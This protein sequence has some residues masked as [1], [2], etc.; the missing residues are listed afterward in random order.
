MAN[1]GVET[2]PVD[3]RKAGPTASLADRERAATAGLGVEPSIAPD[4]EPS[5]APGATFSTAPGGPTDWDLVVRAHDQREAGL[6]V[7]SGPRGSD[8][9]AFAVLFER[10]AKAVFTYLLRLTGEAALAEDLVQEAFLAAY[11]HLGSLRPERAAGGQAATLRPWLL[12]VARNL[13]FSHFRRG[14][15]NL[16]PKRQVPPGLTEANSGPPGGGAANGPEELVLREETAAEVRRAVSRLSPRYRDPLLLHYAAGL[17]YAET[18]MTL[19]LPLGTVATRLRRG[20]T[21]LAREMAVRT[22]GRKA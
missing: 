10:H 20:V 14:R 6:A 13:A 17:T 21:A 16:L 11:R 3:R 7:G 1:A 4:A 18:A 12:R 9:A 2:I 15:R 8:E 5:V 22:G 19:G